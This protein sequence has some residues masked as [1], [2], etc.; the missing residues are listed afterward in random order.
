M[1]TLRDLA[2]EIQENPSQTSEL[3]TAFRTTSS[4]IRDFLFSLRQV[5]TYVVPALIETFA[6][7][8]R[9]NDPKTIRDLMT[10]EAYVGSFFV[11]CEDGSDWSYQG[12]SSSGK[13]MGRP[14]SSA[15]IM[16]LDPDK[17]I[18]YVF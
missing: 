9:E 7:K 3:L 14:I 4:E 17:E 15:L 18:R 8:H 11:I 16:E 12:I 1:K 5:P 13:P 6:Q 10:S 2:R